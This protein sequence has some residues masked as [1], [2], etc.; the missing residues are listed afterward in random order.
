MFG[1]FQKRG[2]GFKQIQRKKRL[3]RTLQLT[4]IGTAFAGMGFIVKSLVGLLSKITGQ[5]QKVI[6]FGMFLIGAMA[7]V[8]KKSMTPKQQA[9]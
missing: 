3:D 7:S 5:S 8:V 4:I 9:A 2:M 6:A 1:M